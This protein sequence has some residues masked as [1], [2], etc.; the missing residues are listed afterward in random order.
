MH[1][2]EFLTKIK[3][4]YSDQYKNDNFN[5]YKKVLN[6]NKY[7]VMLFS[8]DAA[9]TTVHNN[10]FSIRWTKNMN[11]KFEDCETWLDFLKNIR[12]FPRHPQGWYHQN[13]YVYD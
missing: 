8:N 10:K 3:Y 12:I 11:I 7:H 13:Q 5:I 9:L 4:K 2:A 6:V 1:L